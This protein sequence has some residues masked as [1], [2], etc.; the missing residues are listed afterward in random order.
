MIK[1]KPKRKNIRLEN[2]D[3]DRK[4]VLY[5]LTICT[6]N[7]TKFFINNDMAS[8]IKKQLGFRHNKKEIILLCYCLMP[9][10]LHII[11]SLDKNHRGNLANW[12]KSFKCMST[13]S[14][15]EKFSISKLWQKNFYD[16]IIRHH[17]SLNTRLI[18][19]LENPVRHLLVDSWEQYP[20]NWINPNYF[21]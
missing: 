14:V 18:Y 8:I 4:D 21:S 1:T 3:Y 17:E 10:H 16:H 15:K 12:V 7:K 6:Y 13:K 11:M 20:H 2:F 5:F 19:T 9:D